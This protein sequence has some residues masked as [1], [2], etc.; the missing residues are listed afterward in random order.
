[1]RNIL[2][3]LQWNISLISRGLPINTS[4]SSKRT[5]IILQRSFLVME[6]LRNM[7]SFM[8]MMKILLLVSM[9]QALEWEDLVKSLLLEE[10]SN[11]WISSG[12]R[13]IIMNLK[14]KKLWIYEGEVRDLWCY[15]LQKFWCLFWIFLLYYTL[16]IFNFVSVSRIFREYYCI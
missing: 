1:M 6:Y 13:T 16:N 10:F 4:Y 5:V 12:W 14:S 8:K 9:I 2:S 11:S 3:F 15:Y 7:R